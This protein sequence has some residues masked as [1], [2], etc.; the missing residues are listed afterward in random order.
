M[1]SAAAA[2]GIVNAFMREHGARAPSAYPQ[3][4]HLTSPL[5]AAART[6][7]DGDAINLWAG[8]TYECAQE[9]PAAELLERWSAHAT[10]VISA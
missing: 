9:L 8:Q 1:H 7:G 3:I 4:H 6:A 2:R 5:R 10:S